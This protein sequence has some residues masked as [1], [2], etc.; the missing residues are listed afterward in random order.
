MG[1]KLMRA[2]SLAVLVGL[3]APLTAAWGGGKRQALSDEQFLARALAQGIGEVK[4]S[5]Q[6]QKRAS[7]AQVKQFAEHMV[8]DHNKANDKLLAFARDMKLGVVQGLDKTW[9]ERLETFSRLEGAAYDRDYMKQQVQEHEK[10]VQLFE[11]ES[12]SGTNAALKAFAAETLPT[13]RTHLKKAREI[14]DNL[15]NGK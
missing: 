9:R 10:A 3:L 15:N 2:F 13:I 12:R 6:A 11:A 5:E 14:R 4:L 7:N 1:T 8:R